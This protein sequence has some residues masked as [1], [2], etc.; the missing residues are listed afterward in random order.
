MARSE[1]SL[2]SDPRYGLDSRWSWVTAGFLSW[3]L[4]GAMMTQQASG[5]LFFGIVDTY[6]VS[7]EEASWPLVLC[8]SV[9]CLTGPVVG[10]LCQRF[11]CRPVLMFFSLASA[12][13]VC[14]CYF[15]NS[16]LYLTVV[17]GIV[18]GAAV[19]GVFV[20]VQVLASQHF[21]K[22][23][24]TACS[25][26]FTLCAINMFF[27]APLADLFRVTYGIKG[28]F[29]LLGGLI[30]NAFPAAIAVRNPAWMEARDI[31]SSVSKKGEVLSTNNV[32]VE[33]PLL[34]TYSEKVEMVS[35]EGKKT[36]LESGTVVP[37]LKACVVPNCARNLRNVCSLLRSATTVKGEDGL[38]RDVIANA[39]RFATLRFVLDAFS[40][41]IIIFGLTTFFLLYVDLAA[42]RGVMPTHAA[43]L[44]YAFAAGDLV[45]RALSGVVVDSGILTLDSV[46]TLGYVIQAAGFELL[47]WLRTFPTMM[48]CSALIGISNGFRHS[49]QAPLLVK[50]FGIQHLP[51]MMGGLS[52]CNGLVLLSR[53][54]LVGYYRDQ[55]GSYDGLLHIAAA[56]NSALCLLWAI[57]IFS[58]RG[59]EW[60][61]C[62]HSKQRR[63][64][65]VGLS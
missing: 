14:A 26:M 22:R 51:I 13:S 12:I 50:D 63:Q 28:A 3:L 64:V 36:T 24:A 25:L 54:M 2:K 56:V 39:R 18:H 4:C 40:F 58:E 57:R 46:M 55:Q 21:E 41:S 33:A 48:V 34:T 38:L 7:R 61:R 49:L 37:V 11:S 29:L 27:A 9:V 20:G 65:E 42:D 44:V 1:A 8:A 53:P 5:V 31:D 30:L 52:F 19:S 60:S 43:F 6:G 45:C 16:V 10:Y 59:Q 32:S 23:R 62:G 15:A 47:V 17:L 35:E